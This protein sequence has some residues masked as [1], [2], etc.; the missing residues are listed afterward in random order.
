MAATKKF[1]AS[2]FP[3]RDSLPKLLSQGAISEWVDQL[4]QEEENHY[5]TSAEYHDLPS[6]VGDGWSSP[7]LSTAAYSGS[8]RPM[9]AQA[10]VLNAQ[11]V[12]RQYCGLKRYQR[13]AMAHG[14][15]I[16]NS[17]LQTLLR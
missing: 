2:H 3:R 9:E 16:G 17:A 14:N 4:V 6:E 1:A 10:L 11:A 15:S 5:E 13:Q 7:G 12:V 8:V